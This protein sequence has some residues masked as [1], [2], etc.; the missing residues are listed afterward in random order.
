[1]E[2]IMYKS[3]YIQVMCNLQLLMYC[4]AK[5]EQMLMLILN[6]TCCWADDIPPAGNI[7]LYFR[8]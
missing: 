2:H 1:M 5:F 7:L 8:I 4:T 3:K 6:A